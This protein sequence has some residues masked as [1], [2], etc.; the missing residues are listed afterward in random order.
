MGEPNANHVL[1]AKLAKAEDGHAAA[2]D[3]AMGLGEFCPDG[4]EQIYQHRI[5]DIGQGDALAWLTTRTQ[6]I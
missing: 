2:L 5:G 6:P 1:I 4:I 3:L